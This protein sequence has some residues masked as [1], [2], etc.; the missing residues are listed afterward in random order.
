MYLV[1]DRKWYGF[2]G[3]EEKPKQ[4]LFNAITKEKKER[5]FNQIS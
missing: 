1:Y 4:T 5:E 3:G 2:W